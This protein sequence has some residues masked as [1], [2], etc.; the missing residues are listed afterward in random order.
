MNKMIDNLALP[1]NN[2]IWFDLYKYFRENVITVKGA[3]SHSLKSVGKG[4]FK[5]KLIDTYWDSNILMDNKIHTIANDKYFKNIDTEFNSLIKY[6]E[7]DCKIMYD[8][9]DVIRKLKI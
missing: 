6:N 2:I 5:N 3:F 7:V 4:M 8:I 1:I 9:L